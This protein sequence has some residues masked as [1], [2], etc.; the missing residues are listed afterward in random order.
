MLVCNPFN[1][2]CELKLGNTVRAREYYQQ[3]I[4][5]NLFF[6]DNAVPPVII[7]YAQLLELDATLSPTTKAAEILCSF[8]QV[9]LDHFDRIEEEQFEHYVDVIKKK[10]FEINARINSEVASRIDRLL[11]HEAAIRMECDLAQSIETNLLTRIAN[12]KS[13]SSSEVT[14]DVVFDSTRQHSEYFAYQRL[15]DQSSGIRIVGCLFRE[16]EFVQLVRNHLEEQQ[17]ES[18]GK[19]SLFTEP[20]TIDSISCRTSR[21]V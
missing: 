18:G 16:Y 7:S 5:E 11:K 13:G 20:A 15:P 2:R 8:Y 3:I 1:A 6:T 19:L 21:R 17:L 14:I 12:M 9:L 4:G 10:L